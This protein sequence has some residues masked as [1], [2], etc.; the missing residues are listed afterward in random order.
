M[1]DSG[2]LTDFVRWRSARLADR[3]AAPAVEGVWNHLLTVFLLP[4][5]RP[6]SGAL[7]RSLADLRAQSYANVEVILLGQD[8]PLDT[9]GFLHLRGLFGEPALGPADILGDPATDTLWRGSH[10]LFA[11]A[12]TR[13]DPDALA[14]F[15]LAL[16][17]PA[18]DSA[19]DL[20]LSDHDRPAVDGGTPEPVFL[21]GWDPDRLSCFDY[22]GTAFLASRALVRA[23]RGQA[24]PSSPEDWLRCVALRPAQPSVTLLRE[25]VLRLPSPAAPPRPGLAAAALPGGTAAALILPGR[26]RADLLRSA[27]RL[28]D[29]PLGFRPEPVVIDG[30]SDDPTTLALQQELATRHGARIL[31]AGPGLNAARLVN[32]GAAASTA[33][34]LLALQ[35]PIEA[36]IP[37][38]IDAMIAHA[39]RPEVGVVGA[40][41]LGRDG[42]VRH[43]G[44]GLRPGLAP[45]QPLLL[46]MAYRGA[47]RATPG[48]LHA[49]ET[50]RN[51]QAV[52]GALFATRRTAF[53]A[54]GGFDETAFPAVLAEV[55]Y[56]LRI[57]RAGLRVLCLPARGIVQDDPPG[58]DME[59]ERDARLRQMALA[60]LDARWPDAL[61]LDPFAHPHVE[62][63]DGFAPCF[64][65][66]DAS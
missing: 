40:R 62:P 23:M 41:M 26:N 16:A 51:V 60:Q 50:L 5:A 58:R 48:Y 49:L 22:A 44:L 33:P 8:T 39:L 56:C 20:V 28:L 10:L 43:A 63:G 64:P 9:E 29:S 6:D 14:R 15:N 7:A 38:E 37:A 36:A 11:E 65:W 32:L 21:P 31:P 52:S 17:D 12:G 66:T 1:P 42:R 57:R 34:V 18:H 35:E 46:D 61:A 2:E 27:L 59:A 47:T 4:P 30:G 45:R 25:P 3:Q 19:P 13:F 24:R 54:A 53:D 55:D